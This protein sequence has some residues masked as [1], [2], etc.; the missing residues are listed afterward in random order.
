MAFRDEELSACR[1]M[2]RFF[3]QPTFSD[4]F[5]FLIK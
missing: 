1:N 4:L 3:L 5:V 2:H